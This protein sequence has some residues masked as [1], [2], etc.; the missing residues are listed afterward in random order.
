MGTDPSGGWRPTPNPRTPQPSLG[1]M[2]TRPATDR[3]TSD[4]LH[5]FRC[6]RP[7][8]E[9][10]RRELLHL[11]ESIVSAAAQGWPEHQDDDED[12]DL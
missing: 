4:I 2:T 11:A 3:V 8:V 5:D 1:P 6:R 7:L 9:A 10:D 12:L